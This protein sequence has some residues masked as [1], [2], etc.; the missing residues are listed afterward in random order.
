MYCGAILINTNDTPTVRIINDNNNKSI[1]SRAKD[2]TKKIETKAVNILPNI[3]D[4][5]KFISGELR[6]TVKLAPTKE[7]Q[8]KP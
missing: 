4:G 7:A 8:A 6:I 2:E 1:V 3:Y 5:T